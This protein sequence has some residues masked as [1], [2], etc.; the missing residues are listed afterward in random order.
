M[1]TWEYDLAATSE[2]MAPDQ[3]FLRQATL[4]QAKTNT[5]SPLYG[6]VDDTAGV[7]GHSLGGGST[8]INSITTESFQTPF[9]A[10]LTMSAEIVLSIQTQDIHIPSMVITA[11]NDCLC[12]PAIMAIPIYKAITAKD[13]YIV[14]ITNGTHCQF[15]Q[16]PALEQDV[17]EDVE[18][19]IGK[20]DHCA[21]EHEGAIIL[22]KQRQWQIVAEYG[23][24]W[25]DYQLKGHSVESLQ[26]ALQHDSSNGTL[27]F[28]TTN[29]LL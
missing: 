6:I 8:L 23:R 25:W 14:D 2:D 13:K 1:G 9:K 7:M 12:T 5:S 22:P 21:Q 18:K 3:L 17:C 26:A 10:M 27:T 24:L 20:L 11:S 16:V 29:K 19:E 15:D 28:N 4:N